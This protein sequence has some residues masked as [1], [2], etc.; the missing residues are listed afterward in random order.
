MWRA[1]ILVVYTCV[2]H[3]SEISIDIEHWLWRGLTLTLTLTL[4][5][6]QLQAPVLCGVLSSLSCIRV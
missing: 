3:S 1:V 5:V 4:T 6:L 2:R